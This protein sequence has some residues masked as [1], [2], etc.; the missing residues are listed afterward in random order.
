MCCVSRISGH[1]P[2]S[3]FHSKS[4][5][6]TSESILTG[7]IAWCH[8]TLPGSSVQCQVY[9]VECQ[10]TVSWSVRVCQGVLTRVQSYRLPI[11][12]PP[13]LSP[14]ILHQTVQDSVRTRGH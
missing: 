9:S 11:F 1:I 2:R 10:A 7:Y 12:L 6:V 14:H 8:L 13:T 5:N 4:S 3:I